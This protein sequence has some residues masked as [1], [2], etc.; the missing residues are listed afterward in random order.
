MPDLPNRP[1]IYEPPTGPNKVL[2]SYLAERS[3][4]F[5]RL[6]AVRKSVCHKLRTFELALTDLI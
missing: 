1:Q 6:Q 3:P 2:A 5:V 4:D